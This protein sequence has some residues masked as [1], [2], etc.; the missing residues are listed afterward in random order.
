M[1]DF[2]ALEVHLSICSLDHPLPVLQGGSFSA[3]L[4]GSALVGRECILHKMRRSS[5]VEIGL[6]KANPVISEPGHLTTQKPRRHGSKKLVGPSLFTHEP[7]MTL[8][9]LDNHGENGVRVQN[10]PFT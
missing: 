5:T 7:K 6:A 9:N 1:L 3:S 10:M 4:V 2:E 8:E